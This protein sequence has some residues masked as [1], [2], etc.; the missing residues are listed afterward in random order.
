MKRILIT[1]VLALTA[2]LAPGYSQSV[3]D[4]VKNGVERAVDT[5]KEAVETAVD[6]TS[7][8]VRH[9][10][11]RTKEGAENTVNKIRGEDEPETVTES[12]TVQTTTTTA[13]VVATTPAP[14]AETTTVA[15]TT[16]PDLSQKIESDLGRPMTQAETEKYADALVQAQDQNN[17]AKD[18][19]AAKIHEITGISTEKARQMI[20]NKDL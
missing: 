6:K 5:T 4:K 16:T 10:T 7:S 20:S 9:V 2:T 19:L 13:P 15:T 17:A 8:T 11:E 14:V 3:V 12:R 1:A 18:E